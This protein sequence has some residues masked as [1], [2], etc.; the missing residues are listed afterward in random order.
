MATSKHSKSP[1]NSKKHYVQSSVFT[2]GLGAKTAVVAVDADNG[3]TAQSVQEGSLIKAI[4]LEYWLTSDD[5][6]QG[7]FVISVEKV[8]GGSSIMTYAESIALQTYRNKKNILYT[9]QGLV[10]P[11]DEQPLPL[12]K[13]LILIPKGKQR[14]GLEDQLLINISGI[15]NGVNVCGFATYKEYQ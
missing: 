10:G 12:L 1:I 3:T 11:F 6:A 4:W 2:V 5:S 14:F 9:T 13:Q 7:S 15:T 8:P